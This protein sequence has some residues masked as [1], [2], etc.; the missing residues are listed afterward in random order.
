[1]NYSNYVPNPPLIYSDQQLSNLAVNNDFSIPQVSLSA[2]QSWKLRVRATTTTNGTLATSFAA[3]QI[4]DGV[5]LVT[6]NRI[7]LKDQTD[8]TQNGIYDVTAGA[9]TRSIDMSTGTNAGTSALF[10][11]EGTV[12]G[13]VGFLCT[14][15][16]GADIVGTSNLIF[17]SFSGGSALI[18]ASTGLL[19]SGNDIQVDTTYAQNFNSVTLTKG[20][21]TQSGGSTSA[22]TLNNACGK[23]ITVSQTL[24]S[25]ASTNFVFNNNTIT[26]SSVII[27]TVDNYVGGGVPYV[28]VSTI[29]NGSCAI[30]IYN[31]G[32][33]AL[34]SAITFGFVVI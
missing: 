16:Y 33:S 7:L 21:A 1:M 24:A 11:N 10:V 3:G 20:T 19:K 26:T 15:A 23:I 31:V 30:N 25:Q 9:P 32:S 18:T 27:V 17:S 4:I 22:V 14:N 28:T 8:Q 6:G 2:A 34:T 29:A 12:N 13:N 5:T